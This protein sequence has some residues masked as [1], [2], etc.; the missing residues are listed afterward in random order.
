MFGVENYNGVATR[1]LKK[2]ENISIRYDK[3]HGRPDTARRHRPR[4]CIA[5]RGDEAI[6]ERN[7]T[8][9]ATEYLIT[10]PSDLEPSRNDLELDL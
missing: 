7:L 3:V 10:V 2:L 1:R 8:I 9:P 6:G 5:S 4:L